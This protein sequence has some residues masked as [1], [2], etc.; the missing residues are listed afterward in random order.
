M[1]KLVP[2][3]S[4]KS[5]EHALHLPRQH[6]RPVLPQAFQKGRSDSLGDS[7]PNMGSITY[8]IVPTRLVLLGLPV[9][10]MVSYRVLQKKKQPSDTVSQVLLKVPHAPWNQCWAVWIGNANE[11]NCFLKAYDSKFGLQLWSWGYRGEVGNYC[12]ETPDGCSFLELG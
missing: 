4:S 7:P 2:L 5:K 8:L 9:S 3:Y 12:V 11:N 6:G 1:P 10:E